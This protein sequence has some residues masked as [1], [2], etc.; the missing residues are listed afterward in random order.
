MWHR[1]DDRFYQSLT[2]LLLYYSYK[3]TKQPMPHIHTQPGQHDHT[4]SAYL[5]RLDFDEPKVMLH[6]HKEYG[7]YMQFGGHIEPHE[8]PWQA[9][10]HELQEESGYDID[11]LQFLQPKDSLRNLT[12]ATVHPNPALYATFRVGSDHFH[13]DSGYAVIAKEPPRHLPADGES[14]AIRLF[15]RAELLSLSNDVLLENVRE[16]ILHIFDI[17]LD[18]WQAVPSNAF[19]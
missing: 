6:L 12:D 19:K 1:E 16:I 18:S 14:T 2:M 13:T 17:Y 9:I 15:S 4:V 11:Q 10:V 5:F 3:L 8:H 7:Q